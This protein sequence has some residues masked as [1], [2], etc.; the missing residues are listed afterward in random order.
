LPCGDHLLGE[1]A[2][3]FHAA[4]LGR[5]HQ[6]GAE[7]LHG[8]GA[9]DGEVLRHDQHHAVALDGRGHRERDAGVA[10][11]GFDQ[12]V[13]GLDFAALLGAL[14]HRKR[15]P[16]LDRSRGIV[17]FELAEDHVAAL[18]V[19]GCID[20]LQGDQRGLA[21]GI[22]DRRIIHGSHCA[23]ILGFVQNPARVVKLVDAGDSKSPTERCAGSIPAPGTID[24]LLS[25]W[26]KG[27]SPHRR[28]AH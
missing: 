25:I 26:E 12:R 23:I 13:A 28:E 14:D 6:F 7:G 2:G 3:V 22:F 20:A 8:L 17:A 10:R 18:G 4:A 5:E 11:S 27:L 16:V 15:R 1:V 24:T 21:N 19:F 9:F